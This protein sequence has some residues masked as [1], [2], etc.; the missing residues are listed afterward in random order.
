[1]LQVWLLEE[2]IRTRLA[3]VAAQ[4]SPSDPSLAAWLDTLRGQVARM[5]RNGRTYALVRRVVSSV[6]VLSWQLKGGVL[7][8]AE[9]QAGRLL[10]MQVLSVIRTGCYH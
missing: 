9:D 8:E 3:S 5:P 10:L 7:T 1:M 2:G 4:P 6:L